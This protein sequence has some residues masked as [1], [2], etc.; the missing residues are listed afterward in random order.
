MNEEVLSIAAAVGAE[1]GR[2]V[3]VG[4]SVRDHLLGIAAKDFDIEVYGVEPAELRAV[5]E[6]IAHVNTVGE[7]FAVYKLTFQRLISIQNVL[8]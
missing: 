8:R 3:L 5:L 6:K 7:H 4:G 1:N 2:A